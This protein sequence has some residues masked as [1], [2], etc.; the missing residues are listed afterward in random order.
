LDVS[1]QSIVSKYEGL[2]M[3]ALGEPGSP[4]SR[5]GLVLFLRRGMWGW[6]LA[7]ASVRPALNT[8]PTASFAPAQCASAVVAL[9]ASMAM[10]FKL[11]RA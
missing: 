2:R 11:R 10:N 7:A 6:A 5:S 8:T 4:E 9:L 1:S 3:A